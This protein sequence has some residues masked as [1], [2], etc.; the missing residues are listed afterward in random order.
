MKFYHTDAKAKSACL[1]FPVPYAVFFLFF[2]FLF[3]VLLFVIHITTSYLE[4]NMFPKTPFFGRKAGSLD[5]S[6][7]ALESDFCEAQTYLLSLLQSSTVDG[8]FWERHSIFIL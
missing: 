2:S 3:I 7:S 6:W 5:I 8:V 4:L 1:P